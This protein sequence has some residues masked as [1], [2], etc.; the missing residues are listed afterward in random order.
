LA[1]QIEAY[2]GGGLLG[3][4][5]RRIRFP[6]ASQSV[7]FFRRRRRL[8]LLLA[9]SPSLVVSVEEV[10]A[11]C[12]KKKKKE[13]EE[14]AAIDLKSNCQYGWEK[15]LAGTRHIDPSLFSTSCAFIDVHIFFFHLGSG[16][17]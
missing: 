3:R 5:F 4:P 7:P 9:S 2:P 12:E 15:K 16:G 13:E 17:Q 1:N 6:C 8:L 14:E 10:S 11:R